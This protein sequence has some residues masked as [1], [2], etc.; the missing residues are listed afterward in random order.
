MIPVIAYLDL[1]TGSS[2]HIPGACTIIPPTVKRLR[3]D[4]GIGMGKYREYVNLISLT[5]SECIE[6]FKL[7]D[8]IKAMNEE[9]RSV[10]D[11]F[12]I[13]CLY[14][15][16]RELLQNALSFFVSETIVFD[17]EKFLFVVYRDSETP[18]GVITRENYDVVCYVILQLCGI[19]TSDPTPM[20][21]A[22][23]HAKELYELAEKGRKKLAHGKEKDES[24]S[25]D[26]IVS[27]LSTYSNSYNL[28]N[29]GDLAVCQVYDQFS[30]LAIKTQLDVAST[31]WAAWGKDPWNSTMWQDRIDLEK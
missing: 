4:V 6:T 5:T 7:Q 20:K 23:E 11:R 17:E 8:T 22:N 26:N 21:F 13:L 24:M 29:V 12:V 27:V 31:R 19:K 1:I 18:V 10:Y 15:Q 2:V 16:L 14:K 9:Q 25:L 30:R 3:S 28:L